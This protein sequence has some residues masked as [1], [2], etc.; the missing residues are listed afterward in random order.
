MKG[1]FILSLGQTANNRQGWCPNAGLS[2]FIAIY[3][4]ALP[5]TNFLGL[6]TIS[7]ILRHSHLPYDI[8]LS[9]P[10]GHGG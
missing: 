6:Q 5:L 1:G 9:S 4:C 3:H 2:T 8:S 7:M 10:K